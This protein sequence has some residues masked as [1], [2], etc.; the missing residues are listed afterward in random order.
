MGTTSVRTLESLY[1]V[2]C[3]LGNHY[4]DEEQNIRVDQWLP[5]EPTNNPISTNEA[6][7]NI[8]DYLERTGQKKMH[9]ETQILIKPGFQFRI[10]KGMITNF[11]QP[12]ST[13]LLLVSAFV[14]ND[15]KRIYDFA[16]ENDFRFLS[17]GDSSVLLS[18]F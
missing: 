12:K 10:I 11:H 14:G 5:Y 15:W 7:Q 9:A 2:G 13:L 8:I 16:L 4:S 17:Y 1:Y 6:L 18:E 3:K